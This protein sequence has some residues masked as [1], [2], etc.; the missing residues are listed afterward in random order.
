MGGGGAHVLLRVHTKFKLIY[1]GPEISENLFNTNDSH[2][3]CP[4]S[5]F[6]LV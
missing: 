5:L 1:F 6:G 2:H 4:P 3:S